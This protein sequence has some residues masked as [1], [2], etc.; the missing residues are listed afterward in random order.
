MRKF[1]RA[2]KFFAAALAALTIMAAAPSSSQAATGSVRLHIVKVGFIIGVGGGNGRLYF[3]HHVYP[4]TLGGIGIGSLGV[5]AV[6]LVGTAS[7]L[8][9]PYDIVGT[10]SV[11][12]AGAA[13]VGGASAA[14]LQNEK[15]VVIQVRGVQAGFQ[16]NVGLGGMTI[17]MP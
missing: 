7:N 1:S 12:G 13:F 6:D 10:Y 14:T 17:N 16:I 4:L 9:S 11:V 8:H 5:A 2:I 15:G 3:N